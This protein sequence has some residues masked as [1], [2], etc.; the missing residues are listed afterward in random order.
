VNTHLSQSESFRFKEA[1]ESLDQARAIDPGRTAEMLSLAG[2]RSDRPVVLDATLELGSV[3][4]AAL[5]GG[6]PGRL[7]AAGAG[8]GF[9]WLRKQFVN[10]VTI[11]AAL[12]LAACAALGFLSRKSD[13]ARRCIRC[14]RPFCRYCK[15][16]R[17]GHEYCSQCLH[18]YV[19][20]DG[21]APET[22]TLKL[23]EVER[24]ERLH[25][26]GRRLLST[27]LPGAAQLLRGKAGAG[28]L[29]ILAWLTTLIA[30]QPVIL[31]PLERVTGAG[32]LLDALRT[33]SVPAVFNMNALGLV[34]LV[35]VFVVWIAGNLWRWRGREA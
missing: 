22:K 4:E 29:L 18:L 14:G 6:D 31:T 20:G 5:V 25:R 24:H 35:G 19:L 28:V 17:E 9:S 33:G 26:Y 11:L 2:T 34:A 15:S 23:Y 3:W 10:P 32:L 8:D 30:W 21:L 12:G 27:I 13:P 7:I 1:E 16:G